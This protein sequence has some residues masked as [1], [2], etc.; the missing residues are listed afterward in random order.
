MKDKREIM[1]LKAASVRRGA[2][3]PPQPAPSI[4]LAVGEVFL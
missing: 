3:I 1:R 2:S 4:R